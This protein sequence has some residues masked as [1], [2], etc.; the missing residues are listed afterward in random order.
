MSS[1][2]KYRDRAWIGAALGFYAF[3]AIGIAEGGLGV[4]LP[5][6][7][8]AFDLNPGTVTLLFL[9]QVSGYII[10]AMASSVLASRIGLAQMLLLASGS[11]TLSLIVY[12][13]SPLWAIMVAA[14]T[15]LGLG[16]G[17]IDAGINTY[18]ANDERNANLLGLLHAFYGIGALSGPAVATTLLSFGLEWRLV[19]VVIAGVVGITIAGMAGAVIL[20]YKPLTKKVSAADTDAVANV[21]L[22][23]KTPIVLMSGLMLLIYVG[24]E[25]SVGNWAY[26][27]QIMSRDTPEVLAGYSV[28]A[29]WLGLTF[30]RLGMQQ[31]IARLGAI[32]TLDYSLILL[33]VSLSA[34][35]LLPGQLWSLPLIGLALGTIFPTTILLTPKRVAPALVP[36]AIG[37][38]T[39][40]ASLG[41]ATIPTAIGWI[42]A[43]SSLGIVPFLMLPLSGV[44]VGLHRWLVRNTQTG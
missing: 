26:S 2:S 4:L 42:A 1:K 23:L 40:T 22:A 39:S 13:I 19:Y 16:I 24:V 8:E 43:Q 33:L 36:A 34:W 35:W 25:A 37:F 11:L 6:I 32:R 12:A 18:F 38:L 9:S 31:A 41:A 17:L 20:N 29:Y 14:G 15:L 7:L 3:I 21:R 5:S 27:V 30:G 10:A 44:M 28:S